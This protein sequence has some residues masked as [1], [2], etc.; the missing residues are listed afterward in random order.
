M[1]HHSGAE[2]R[3]SSAGGCSHYGGDDTGE[4]ADQQLASS[5]GLRDEMEEDM[6]SD[7]DGDQQNVHE[8]A[9]PDTKMYRAVKQRVSHV[10]SD[11]P[12][13]F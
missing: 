6:G 12:D 11:L 9:E 3:P 13:L 1:P 2:G 4:Q 10:P 8:A 7:V 5:L